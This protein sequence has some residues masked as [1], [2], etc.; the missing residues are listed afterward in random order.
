[1]FHARTWHRDNRIDQTKFQPSE[2]LKRSSNPASRI[3]RLQRNT[4]G[5]RR[6][7]KQQSCGSRLYIKVPDSF[8]VSFLGSFNHILLYGVVSCSRRRNLLTTDLRPIGSLR[9]FQNDVAYFILGRIISAPDLHQPQK[10]RAFSRQKQHPVTATQV[11]N[12]T[13]SASRPIW[14]T[15]FIKRVRT[16]GLEKRFC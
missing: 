5:R 9:L 2:T 8:L 12:N 1:M 7:E 16:R 6:N 15:G 11:V 4:H 14:I 3:P 13:L 10:Q